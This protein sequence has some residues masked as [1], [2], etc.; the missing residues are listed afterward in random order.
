VIIRTGRQGGGGRRTS[1]HLAQLLID[2]SIF[3]SFLLAG[4][5]RG[6]VCRDIRLEIA[7]KYDLW[8]IASQASMLLLAVLVGCVSTNI[9]QVGCTGYHHVSNR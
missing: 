2:R 8:M 5:V 6:C 3:L 1:W 7:A 9:T 4:G